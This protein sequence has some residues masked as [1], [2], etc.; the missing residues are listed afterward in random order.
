[1]SLELAV[2]DISAQLKHY[3]APNGFRQI[4]SENVRSN[5]KILVFQSNLLY[6]CN[7]FFGNNFS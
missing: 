4:K 7:A 1:M 5:G 3:S 2:L 6:F